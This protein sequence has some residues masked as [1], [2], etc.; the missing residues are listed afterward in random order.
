MGRLERWG[1]GDAHLDYVLTPYEPA[2]S[3]AGKLRPV[4]V[5]HEALA[6]MGVADEGAAVVDRV[7]EALGD[8]R[9]VFGVKHVAGVGLVG[10]E[11]YFYDPGRTRGDVSI[12]S[13]VALLEGLVDVDARP[14]RPLA[15]HMISVELSPA[16][17]RRQARAPVHVYLDTNA[18]KGV[19]RS[20]ELR[21]DELRLENVYSFHDPRTEMDEILHRLSRSAFFSRA[22]GHLGELIPPEL[23]DCGHVC[24][25]NKPTAD[26]LYFS[27]V[28]TAQAR[29]ALEWLGWPASFLA[30]VDARAPELDHARW[31]VGFDF[32]VAGGEVRRDRSG[33]HGTF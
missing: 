19:D 14:P 2:A 13:L 32:A 5:L 24:V 11:L 15:W 1:P 22:E 7:R 28:T 10:C 31:D 8:N 27:R 33:I 30:F 4:S 18:H 29:F 9:T 26:A 25:A 6:A 23:L 3:P 20:Y 17:L 12:A 21:G 16:H